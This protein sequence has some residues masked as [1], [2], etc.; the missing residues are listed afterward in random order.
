VWGGEAEF[1][2]LALGDKLRLNGNLTAEHGAIQGR[3]RT[4]DSTVQQRIEASDPACAFG[5][6]YYNP[7]CWSAVI[8]S[9]RDIGGNAPP[10]TPDFAGSL[11]VS[12]LLAAAGGVLT[13][14]VEYVYRG[15]SW[16]RVFEEPALDKVKAY[17]IWNLNLDYAPDDGNYTLSLTASNLLNKAGVNSRYTDP[18]GTFQTSQQFIAPR[19]IIGTIGYSF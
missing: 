1:S 14:R 2:Y 9:A 19:Q 7:A 5:G 6:A 17:G 15:A 8:A 13:P 18:Y 11:N 16:S 3:Y 12:Y 4:I 10:K